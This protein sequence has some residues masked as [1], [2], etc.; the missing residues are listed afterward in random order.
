MEGRENKPIKGYDD[1]G[2]QESWEGHE[3]VVEIRVC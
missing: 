2:G 1:D 3:Q